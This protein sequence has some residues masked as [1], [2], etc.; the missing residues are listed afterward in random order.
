[1]DL[2]NAYQF[3]DDKI[4]VLVEDL[5]GTSDKVKRRLISAQL[6]N[7]VNILDLL[8]ELYGRRKNGEET[9]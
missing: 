9:K 5:A 7:F 1:M 8:N 3:I 4:S 2:F 6:D